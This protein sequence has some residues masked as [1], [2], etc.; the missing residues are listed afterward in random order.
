MPLRKNEDLP[1]DLE[2][3]LITEAGLRHTTAGLALEEARA[4]GLDLV[5]VDGASAPP[6]CKLLDYAK[7]KYEARRP[8]QLSSLGKLIVL[9]QS[10]S[11][12]SALSEPIGELLRR[13]VK[14]LSDETSSIEHRAEAFRTAFNDVPWDGMSTSTQL[15]VEE[16]LQ[17]IAEAAGLLDAVGDLFGSRPR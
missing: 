6:T 5:E 13:L 10:D 8:S 2:I 15:V 12:A 11:S 4:F 9:E 14:A 7:F 17:T 1:P 16:H 3:R